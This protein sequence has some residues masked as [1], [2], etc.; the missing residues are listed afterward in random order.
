MK[1]LIILSSI[2]YKYDCL[3]AEYII[4]FIGFFVLFE[5]R[6]FLEEVNNIKSLKRCFA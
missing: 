3:S 1:A 5:F 2:K 4:E 6:V